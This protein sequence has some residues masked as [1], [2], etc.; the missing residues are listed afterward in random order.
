MM[1]EDIG[2]KH[3]VVGYVFCMICDVL[4]SIANS[5]VQKALYYRKKRKEIDENANNS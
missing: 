5:F 1:V 2:F 4:F 3:F